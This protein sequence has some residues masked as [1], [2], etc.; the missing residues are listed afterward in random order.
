MIIADTGFFVALANRDDQHHA[1]AV[2]AFESL[3]EPLITTWPVLTETSH[4]LLHRLGQR[5]LSAFLGSWEAGAFFT[6]AIPAEAAGHM[7]QLVDKYRDLPMDLADASPVVLAEHLGHGRILS[8]DRRD[9]KTYRWKGRLPFVNV[10]P[11]D[12]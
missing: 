1:A 2:G 11:L 4:L 7:R 12:D 8:T 10:L 6:L 3:K 5:A 9:F